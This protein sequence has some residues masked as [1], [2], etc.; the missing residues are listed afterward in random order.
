M[1]S[2]RTEQSA[3]SSTLPLLLQACASRVSAHRAI[4]EVFYLR[5]Q[6]RDWFQVSA[7]RA[8]SEVFYRALRNSMISRIY[9]SI[10]ERLTENGAKRHSSSR[11]RLLVPRFSL[12]VSP[13]YGPCERLPLFRRHL[14]ARGISA[15]AFPS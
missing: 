5:E 14:D 9:A 3:R 11:S 7:H 2:R 12:L 13:S 15:S 4:S 8:I 6:A 1:Q 10:C